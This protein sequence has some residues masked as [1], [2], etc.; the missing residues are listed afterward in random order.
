MTGPNTRPTLPVP[1][2]WTA[3]SRTITTTL[4]GSTYCL[5]FGRRDLDALYGRQHRD[6]RRDDAVAEEQA[7]ADDADQRQR[8]A[9]AR[10]DRHALRQRHQRQDAALAAIVGEQDEQ[11]V[12]HRDDQYE[13]PEDQ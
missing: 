4:I 3:N 11:D 9:D 10:T 8:T 13:R 2:H 12:F 5:Q 7:G 6:R 1:R